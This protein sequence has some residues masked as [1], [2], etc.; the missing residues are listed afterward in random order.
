MMDS[1][2]KKRYQE[3]VE[4]QNCNGH[5]NVHLDIDSGKY[6]ELGQW[7]SFQRILYR[8]Q[9]KRNVEEEY[10]ENNDHNYDREEETPGK[11][12]TEQIYLLD[13]LNF[14]DDDGI[15]QCK[16]QERTLDENDGFQSSS[17]GLLMDMADI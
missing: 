10:P 1:E 16:S 7:V 2:W 11:L 8:E 13:A 6:Q 15:E 4:F 3:L 5:T 12:T 17:Q 9:K 14:G